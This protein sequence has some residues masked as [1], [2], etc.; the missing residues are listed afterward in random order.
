MGIN[1]NIRSQIKILKKVGIFIKKDIYIIKNNV[2]DKV[3][4]G[5]SLDAKNRF[6]SHCKPSAAKKENS[7]IAKAIQKYGKEKFW[8]EILESQVENYNEREE[9]W[10]NYYDSLAPKGYNILKGGDEPP[11]LKGFTHP[12]AKL[13][14]GQVEQLTNDLKNTTMSFVELA[15]KYGFKSNSS[16]AEFNKGL[17]YVR[18]ISYPIRKDATNGKLTDIDVQDIIQLL[19]FTFRS[20]K[21]IAQQFGV[22][23]RAI[24][25]INSGELHKQDNIKYPIRTWRATKNTPKFTYEQVTEIIYL[26]QK[27]DFSLREIAKKYDAEYRDISAINNG[28]VKM[29][30]R[31]G[32]TYPL[33][34]RN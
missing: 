34:K 22:E 31:E 12:E 13:T 10:I 20:Y 23:Y 30:K 14:S 25:R 24:K 27:T 28:I 19:K 17:T 21:D 15:K 16:I 29:Y 33:R 3:Y 18:N 7:Y 8:F 6:I 4:I 9:Y 11:L 5:Q 26:L 2:N 32:L 1:T